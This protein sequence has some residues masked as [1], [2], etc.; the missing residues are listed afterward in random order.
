GVDEENRRGRGGGESCLAGQGSG[1]ICRC[2]QCSGSL[3][4]GLSLPATDSDP[5]LA[6]PSAPCDTSATLGTATPH[7]F[8]SLRPASRPRLW[9]QAVLDF[10]SEP[11][12]MP[13]TAESGSSHSEESN[14]VQDDG[15]GAS[16]ATSG[17]APATSQEPDAAR[18]L[19]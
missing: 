11:G 19:G 8:E 3:F 18:S 16:G 12:E 4:T 1:A 2:P 14:D 10:S 5:G 15:N 13:K 6:A 17:V 7:E 9:R